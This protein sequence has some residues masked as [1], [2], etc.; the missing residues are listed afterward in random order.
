[1]GLS[2]SG[3]CINK[4]GRYFVAQCPPENTLM[5]NGGLPVMPLLLEHLLLPLPLPQECPNAACSTE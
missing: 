3:G 2:F 4:P 1:V 5:S